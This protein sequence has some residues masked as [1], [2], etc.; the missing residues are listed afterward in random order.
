MSNVK[1]TWVFYAIGLFVLGAIAALA[2]EHLLFKQA[3]LRDSM[4]TAKTFQAWQLICAP[5]TDK[6]GNCALQSAIIDKATGAPLIQL[7]LASKGSSD[8]LVI[9]APLGVLIPPGLRF[10][11]GSDQ[12][13]TVAFKTCMRTGCWAALPLD[14]ALSTAM[15]QNAG[16]QIVVVGN[17]GKAAALPFSLRG[18]GEALAARAADASARKPSW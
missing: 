10:S 3:D 4:Q 5:R 18:F 1:M 8:T 11:I 2:G 16:G 12:P 9:V 6:N 13:K 14:S 7:T 15:A 17:T